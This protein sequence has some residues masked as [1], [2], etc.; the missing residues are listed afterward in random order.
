MYINEN[1]LKFAIISSLGWVPVALYS[2]FIKNVNIELR[3]FSLFFNYSDIGNKPRLADHLSIYV[4]DILFS[5]MLIPLCIISIFYCF[6]KR[7]TVFIVSFLSTLVLG[8]LFA[9]MHSW[10]TMGKPLNFTGLVDAAVFAF[11]SPK[12]ISMY[13]DYDS[14]LKISALV[15]ASLVIYIFGRKILK[16]NI[17]SK[18]TITTAVLIIF[19]SLIIMVVGLQ[20]DMKK[21]KLFD[22]FLFLSVASFMDLNRSSNTEVLLAD[23]IIEEYNKFTKTKK[24]NN[25]FYFGK[26]KDND[27]IVF[28]METAP[29]EFVDIENDI[30]SFPAIN[31]LKINS[32]ISYNHYATYPGSAQS[33]F[34]LFLSVYPPFNY[35]NSCISKKDV[36]DEPFPGF[37]SKLNKINYITNLYLPYK[38]VIPIDKIL[39]N[40]LG[41][42]KIYIG[43]DY[44][45]K[46]ESY[47]I[48]ALSEM[49]KDI[50][51]LIDKNQSYVTVFCPQI[52]HAPWK[53]RP[54]SISV[55]K[56]GK[57]LAIIQDRWIGEIVDLL[58]EKNM[59]D[60]TTILITADH[61][62]RT[63]KEDPDFNMGFIDAYSYHVPLVVFS[64]SA[65]PE[66]LIIRKKTS[67]LDISPSLVDLFG[68]NDSNLIKQGVNLWDSY[69]DNRD[70]YFLGN[71]H[72]NADGYYSNG[73]FNM[74]NEAI[75]MAF[76]N[77][78]L[79]FKFDNVIKSKTI[80]DG[81][82]K[83]ITHIYSIQDRFYSSYLCNEN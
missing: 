21:S 74:Y 31:K 3:Y 49:K 30:K 7:K 27:L 43:Q 13:V 34:S 42:D 55:K 8:L 53:E 56:Y 15:I 73:F 64:K 22:N 19:A 60:K 63:A 41:F 12:F 54:E 50:G 24:E 25:S 67:H 32:L 69:I 38:D 71:W 59:L 47:D 5:F 20:S 9:N 40:N 6:P 82:R 29:V 79:K 18:I 11:Q 65:F 58:V 75:D 76:T 39:H 14:W 17:I 52:G 37:I 2:I 46:E 57:K 72:C 83:K 44:G 80:A 48:A 68:L 78:S 70:L 33:L 16:V 51:S 28:I 26:A 62:I 10:G 45:L 81:V 36:F 61:G 66:N 23:E 77:N 35:Y 4:Q 1:R